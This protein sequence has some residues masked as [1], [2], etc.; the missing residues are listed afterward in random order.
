MSFAGYSRQICTLYD[1]LSH[2]KTRMI[3]RSRNTR[4]MQRNILVKFYYLILAF[5][6]LSGCQMPPQ[7]GDYRHNEDTLSVA[8][9]RYALSVGNAGSETVEIVIHNGTRKTVVFDKVELD[10]AELPK[11]RPSVHKALESFNHDL[12]G[13]RIK[14][15]A[16]RAVVGARWWQFYPTE[17]IKAGGYG[18]FQFNFIKRSR[19][20][21]LKFTTT[22][23]LD[24]YALVSRYV[25]PKR[26]IEYLSFSGDGTLMSVRYSKGAKPESFYVN[27]RK[28]DEVKHLRLSSGCESGIFA[29][30]MSSRVNEGEGVFAELVFADGSCAS[31]FIRAM[32]GICTVAP[33]GEN[34]YTPLSGEERNKYG[35][36][37]QM[38]IFRLP[39]DIACA[40]T[41]SGLYGGSAQAV[42]AS[43]MRHNRAHGNQLSGVDFCTALYPEVWNIYSQI[44]DTVISKPYKLHWGKTPRR[45]IDEEDAFIAE[46]V[47]DVAPRPVIWVPDRFRWSRELDG[48]EFE[49]LAWCAFMR[50]ARGMR[51]HHWFNSRIEP[52]AANQGLSDAVCGFNRGLNKLRPHLE[53][54]V[55]VKCHEMR[56]KRIKVYE[57]W[58]S[59]EGILLLVR[60]L[61][62][63]IGLDAKTMRRV[64]PYSVKTMEHCRFTLSSP[65]W[66]KPNKAIDPLSGEDV[67]IKGLN[68][69]YEIAFKD[70]KSYKLIWIPSQCSSK[71]LPL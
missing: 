24:L 27:G 58:C 31:A 38:R 7:S 49:T 5:L 8:S 39:Y 37:S 6:F 44:A 18:C 61:C 13:M 42:V 56:N 52:F 51:V 32:L 22:D 43:R 9:I 55:P 36:D 48:K 15:A 16:S 67:S 21:R 33:N 20:C 46:T 53:K 10:G 70:L 60:N 2:V 66:F 47:A 40:D 34:D 59:D 1:I 11:I 64:R 29:A 12:G 69:A 62:Y 25:M 28:L 26:R 41:K 45:F 63:D 19:P 35:F 14:R 54:M 50:G 23:G 4:V 17:E 71:I 3:N 57:S 65:S 68:N 30:R